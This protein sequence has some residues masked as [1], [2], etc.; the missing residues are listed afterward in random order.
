MESR[1]QDCHGFP[2]MAQ[3]LAALVDGESPF[4]SATYYLE[5]DGSLIFSCYKHLATAVACLVATA[6][7]FLNLEGVSHHQAKGNVANYNHLVAKGKA[8]ITPGL[9]FFQH[10]FI[11]EFFLLIQHFAYTFT[12]T[13]SKVLDASTTTKCYIHCG[14]NISMLC[15]I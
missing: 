8:C 3:E 13:N 7:C 5:G 12:N 2:Y 11:R 14:Q 6:R 10:L 9:H 15:T 4:T 1:I